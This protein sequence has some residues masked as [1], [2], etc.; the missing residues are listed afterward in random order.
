MKT[1]FKSSEIAHIFVNKGASYGESP[2]AMSFNSDGFYSYGTVIAKHI[3]HKSKHA[4]LK[5][6]TGYSVS[7]SNHQSKLA[8]SIPSFMTVFRIG[9]IGQGE[10]LNH[11]T[12][13][14]IFEY[15]VRQ[16]TALQESIT[17]LR[18]QNKKDW[19]ASLVTE[20]LEEAKKANEFFGLKR[21]VDEKTIERLAASKTRAEKK[22][23]K[24]QYDREA[25]AMEDQSEAYEMWKK[26]TPGNVYFAP[27]LFPVAFRVEG[28]ELVSSRGARV[29]IED[30]KRALRFSLSMRTKGW[31]KGDGG[32]DR[33][34]PYHLDKISTTGLTAGCHNISWSEL[35]RIAQFPEFA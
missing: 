33:V 28:D 6:T 11:V 8:F 10:R 1:K 18:S 17:R 4:L 16:A 32:D 9:D 29:T 30:A 25:K 24:D 27:A 21:K 12:G 31:V 15:A 13:A 34:G 7:T 35:D 2:S 14:M 19:I 26:N 22:A 5:N 20:W 3:E 23:K